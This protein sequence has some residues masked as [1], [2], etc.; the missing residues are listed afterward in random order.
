MYN[1][2]TKQLIAPK[3]TCTE[4][5]QGFSD[6]FDKFDTAKFTLDTFETDPNDDTLLE[7]FLRNTEHLDNQHVMAQLQTD[8]E[9]QMIPQVVNSTNMHPIPNQNYQNITNKTFTWQFL[10]SPP[11]SAKS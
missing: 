5:N 11:M 9:N 7:N 2:L 6:K 10:D 1:A 3:P 8:K 4:V